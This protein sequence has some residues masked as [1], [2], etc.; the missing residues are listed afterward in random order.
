MVTLD[1]Y[2]LAAD[3][4]WIGRYPGELCRNRDEVLE[5]LRHAQESGVRA[6]AEVVWEGADTLVV[7]PHLDGAI[8]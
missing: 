5:M 7:D 6:E 3:V 2:E 4:V 1:D 8:R